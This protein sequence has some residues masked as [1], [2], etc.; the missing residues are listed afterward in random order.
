MFLAASKVKDAEA[1][2][3]EHIT[4]YWKGKGANERFDRSRQEGIQRSILLAQGGAARYYSSGL[5]SL[6]TEDTRTR[7]GFPQAVQFRKGREGTVQEQG[8]D[9][10]QGLGLSV[11]EPQA[12]G[13][14]PRAVSSLVY[15]CAKTSRARP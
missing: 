14:D 3:K 5:T 6:R 15:I 8:E 2:Y 1:I 13:M 9:V 4:K 12:K 7:G 11:A 10:L